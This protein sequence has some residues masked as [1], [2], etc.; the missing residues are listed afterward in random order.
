MISNSQS[1]V[2]QWILAIGISL[3]SLFITPTYSSEPIDLPKMYALVLVAFWAFAN[4]FTNPIKIFR[5]RYISIISLVSLFILQMLIVILTSG[6]PKNQQIFG[7]FGRNTG[8]VTY[9]ALFMVLVVATFVTTARFVKVV[10]ISLMLSGL[11]SLIYGLMQVTGFDPINWN[12]PNSSM[13]GFLGNPD[14]SSAFLGLVGAGGFVLLFAKNNQVKRIYKIIILSAE[15]VALGLIIKSHAIQGL[16]IYILGLILS[17]GLHLLVRKSRK[18]I[19]LSYGSLSV[20]VISIGLLGALKIGPLANLLYKTSVRQRGFYW[21]AAREMLFSHPFSGIGLDSYGDWYYQKR[22]LNAAFHSMTTTSNAAHNM[23]LDIGAYGGFPLLF[24]YLAILFLIFRSAIRIIKNEESR[25]IFILAL[26]VSWFAYEA[27][28]IVS[29]NQIGLGVWGWLLGGVILGYDLNLQYSARNK[30]EPKSKRVKP[31]NSYILYGLF[32]LG[33][34]F[35]VIQPALQADHNYRIAL[36]SRDANK[37]ISSVLSYP[38]DTHRTMEAAINLAK[39]NLKKQ[40]LELA[41]H[42]ITVNPRSYEAWNL[43]FSLTSQTSSEHTLA[44]NKLKALNPHD[45]TIK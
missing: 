12:N 10:L 9:T 44:S 1:K 43:I 31:S 14:F 8:F 45:K 11:S 15:I 7:T 28:S 26:I 30:P 25:N 20:L 42:V 35:A 40:A 37:V 32:G 29:I 41:H 6:S 13:I 27:Q 4:T 18:L 21:R 33:I 22:S 19:L 2:S 5:R 36:Q 16:M 38:E 3:T 17:F 24:T 34:G 23:I 39:A